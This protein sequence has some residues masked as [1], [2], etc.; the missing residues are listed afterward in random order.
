MIVICCGSFSYI[1][2]TRAGQCVCS[3]VLLKFFIF[4][5]KCG[6]MLEWF[7]VT[8]LSKTCSTKIILTHSFSH[9][10]PNIL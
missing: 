7:L 9:G 6:C 8:E 5:R 10:H 2:M 4:V 3:I 1:F